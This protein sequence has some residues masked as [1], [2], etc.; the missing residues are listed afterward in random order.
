VLHLGVTL[1]HVPTKRP[2]LTLTETPAMARRLE[3]AASRFPER[4]ASRTDLLLAL[5]EIAEETLLLADGDDGGRA[6]AK[7]RLLA[8]TQ[9]IPSDAAEAMIAARAQDWQHESVSENWP[10]GS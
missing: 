9:S 7:R 8:R 6:A 10:R 3:L 1:V 4:A 2:R 5:T